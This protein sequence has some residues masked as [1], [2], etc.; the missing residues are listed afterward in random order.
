MM[1]TGNDYLKTGGVID[2]IPYNS[3]PVFLGGSCKVTSGIA[4]YTVYFRNIN[5]KFS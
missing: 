2:Y 5:L 4:I 1:Y 3:V